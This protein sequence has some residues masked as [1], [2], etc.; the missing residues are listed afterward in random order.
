[1]NIGDDATEKFLDQVL[2]AANI[3]RQHLA[4]KIP[5]KWLTQKQWREYNNATNC[6]I[7]TKSF[8]YLL[9]CIMSADKKI[10]SHDYLTG[11][12]RGPAHNACNLNY[13]NDP[14]K[15]KIPCIIHN[16]KGIVSMLFSGIVSKLFSW[17]L[18]DD[19]YFYDS[20][21]DSYFL[22]TSYPAN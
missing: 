4:N 9:T 15:V 13:R 17:L 22:F 11:E 5:I 14:K 10:C 8:I 21:L 7:C 6:L 19:S 2:A 12:F 16:L 1:M 18:V 3:C 20:H